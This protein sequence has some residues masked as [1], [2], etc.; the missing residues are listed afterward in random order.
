MT[1][2]E[3]IGLRKDFGRSVAVA[4]L[5]LCVAAGEVFGFLGPNGAGK[6]TT[7]KMLLG[8]VRPTA[9]EAR[10]L[11]CAP[12]DAASMGRVGFLPEHFRFPGWLSARGLLDLH[13]RLWHLPAERRRRRIGEVLERVGLADA[14]DARLSTYSKGMSQRIGLAQALLAE[15]EVVFLDEP[16]SALDPLGRREVREIIRDLRQSG[17]TIFL[18]SHLLSEVE[19][20]CDRVAIVKAGRL[21]RVGRLADLTGP[22]L[23][24]EVR[25]DG[26]DPELVNQL[27]RFGEVD[28]LEGG[29]LNLTVQDETVLPEVARTLVAGGASLYALAPQHPSLE[30]LFVRALDESP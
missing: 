3:C 26:L 4:D 7:V 14:A 12:G 8:L 24:V 21:I 23:R 18:N 13:G 11:G 29:R 28:G 20:T 25:A 2:I 9:G 30:E 5:D 27:R 15:P 1:A 17:V 6:T 10:V 22:G 19:I 16:T